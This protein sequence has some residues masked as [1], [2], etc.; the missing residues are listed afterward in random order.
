MLNYVMMMGRLTADPELRTTENGNEFATF[1]IAVQRPKPKDGDN[2][3]DFFNC[4]A[5]RNRAK[6]VSEWYHKGDMIM[7]VGTLRNRRYT[8]K[9]GNNRIAEQIIVKEIHFTGGQ[10]KSNV[11]ATQI[12]TS[13]SGSLPE[14]L[15]EL[16]AGV[17]AVIN[18]ITNPLP[19]EIKVKVTQDFVSDVYLNIIGG[20]ENE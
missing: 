12:E 4:V 8:D 5:W 10:R 20:N 13:L 7:I 2:E 19:Q 16:A 14:I 17:V 18:E 9:N 6:I 15:T 11:Q 1:S 3:T